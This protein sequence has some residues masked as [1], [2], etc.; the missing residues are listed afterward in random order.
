M[1]LSEQWLREWVT[2]NLS[3]EELTHKLTMAG[4]GV[5]SCVPVEDD[6]IYEFELTPNRADCFSTLGIAREIA[7]IT[8]ALLNPPKPQTH[9]ATI[10]NPINI[11]IE[12]PKECPKYIGRAIKNL[13]NPN[14]D[15]QVLKNVQQKIS[16]SGIK[17]IH[18]IVDIMNYVMLELGQPLHAFDAQKIQGNQIKVRFAK[19]NE[20][21]T[22]LDQKDIL[23][24]KTDSDIL[25]ISDQHQPIAIAGIMGGL[26]SAVSSSTQEIF[27]ESA[28]FT[29]EVIA[30]RAR[31]LGLHTDAQ[32]RFERGVDPTLP[33]MAIERATELL[34]K[35][36]PQCQLSELSEVTSRD[37]IFIPPKILCR[38]SK[39]ESVLGI[40]LSNESIIN[41]FKKLDFNISHQ[42]DISITV[43]AKHY[44]FDINHEIDLIEEIARI[45]G[46]EN[47]S[48]NQDKSFHFNQGHLNHFHQLKTT[49]FKNYLVHQGYQE[50]ITYSF[51]SEQDQKNF[52]PNIKPH[53]L[54][55]PLSSEYSVMRTNL[56][57][58]LLQVVLYNANRQQDYLRFFE[59]G[60]CFRENNQESVLSGIWA[61]LS[62][63][64]QWG[65]QKREVDFYDIKNN[66]EQLLGQS[67]KNTIDFQAGNHPAL[68]PSKTAEIF[69]DQ[70]SI[71]FCGGLHPNLSHFYNI[72]IPIYLFEIN[73]SLLQNSIKHSTAKQYQ[74]FSK[75][76]SIRRDIAVLV[77]SSITTNHLKKIIESQAGEILVDI[78]IFD[79]YQDKKLSQH[80]KSI[81]IGLTFQRLERTLSEDEV[82]QSMNNIILALKSQLQVTLRE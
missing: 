25:I 18:P 78:C 13:T 57:A 1:K 9:P 51:I 4:I 7:I 42:D 50:V 35:I 73:L 74:E 63:P 71:G 79:V 68:H 34:C 37:L 64:E 58:G 49:S 80:Q 55:N 23:F 72:K 67:F 19:E 38:F 82:Q 36:Y 52:D 75:F 45:Y 28:F 32:H 6:F 24:S 11:H 17:L 30:G 59:L 5:E 69:F 40:K 56:W 46:Y 15:S 81:A 65:E 3:R 12:T 61:G 26:D 44:R 43:Q 10:A 16:K 66:V 22:L 60:L 2:L 39:I 14:T 70:H 48:L 62:F 53:Y 27:I 31:R 77:D 20:K 21:I 33:I 41:I 54:E 8:G 29:P 47:I 76:P